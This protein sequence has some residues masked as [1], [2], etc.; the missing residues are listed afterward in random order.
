MGTINP[1]RSR[2]FQLHLLDLFPRRCFHLCTCVIVPMKEE[3][4]SK[5][6]GQITVAFRLLPG[7]VGGEVCI[8]T[9]LMNTRGILLCCFLVT[10]RSSVDCSVFYTTVENKTFFIR[11][12]IKNSIGFS[13]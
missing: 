1:E 7:K 12:D 8:L 13:I 9:C 10:L 11:L 3:L 6:R 4:H 2:V 5:E